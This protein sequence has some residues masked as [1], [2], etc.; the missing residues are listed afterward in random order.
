MAELGLDRLDGLA[1][2]RG[3]A[4]HR[5]AADLVMAELAQPEC[6]LHGA[7]RALVAVEMGR[8]RAIA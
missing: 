1:A 8:E 5:V 7:E 4:G 6:P 3:L 2:G